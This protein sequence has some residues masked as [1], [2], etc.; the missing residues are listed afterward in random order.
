MVQGDVIVAGDLVIRSLVPA[1]PT[2][3]IID[4]T[5]LS[6][7]ETYYQGWKTAG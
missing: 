6:N 7:G 3:S 4:W 2:V 5:T 1:S